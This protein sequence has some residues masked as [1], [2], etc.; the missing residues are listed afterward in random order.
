MA[1]E[2]SILHYMMPLSDCGCNFCRPYTHCGSKDLS[3]Q[4][5]DRRGAVIHAEIL[6]PHMDMHQ[7]IG[8]AEAAHLLMVERSRTALEAG[9]MT[10]SSMRVSMRES[11]NSSGGSC[12]VT[13]QLLRSW[14]N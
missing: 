7:Q 3:K 6:A 13:E 5:V 12:R 1:S 14:L 9:R 4:C 8:P 10:G 11:L 2:S